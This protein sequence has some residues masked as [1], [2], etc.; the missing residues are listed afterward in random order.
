MKI[1][2]WNVNGLRAVLKNSSKSLKDFLDGLEADIICLQETKAASRCQARELLGYT[3]TSTRVS[4][5][6]L[7][8]S[9]SLQ[10]ISWRALAVLLMDIR[11]TSPSVESRVAT[12][13]HCIL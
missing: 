6:S 3:S 13:V 11:R 9:L 8:V 7:H 4:R 2:S 10:R 5:Q 12:Q 1:V